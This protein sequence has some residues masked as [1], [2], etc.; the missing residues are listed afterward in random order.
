MLA[1]IW[2]DFGEFFSDCDSGGLSSSCGVASDIFASELALI[3]R[4]F[5]DDTDDNTDEDTGDNTD[6]DI[7]D[8]TDEGL[9]D[10]CRLWE[11]SDFE[12]LEA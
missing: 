5:S 11:L 4:L 12:V 3:D 8:F 6:D 2:E 1:E 7:D 9:E 10:V